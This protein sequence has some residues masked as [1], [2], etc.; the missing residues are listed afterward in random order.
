MIF[1]TCNDQRHI[2]EISPHE[3]KNLLCW[4]LSQKNI[5]MDVNELYSSA[6]KKLGYQRVGKNIKG[7]LES[8]LRLGKNLGII[9][10]KGM[11]SLTE[12]K[13]KIDPEEELCTGD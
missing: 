3:L 12:A 10:G 6:S 11:V 4:I 1:R 5:K 13:E 7:A 9:E 8:A 2:D